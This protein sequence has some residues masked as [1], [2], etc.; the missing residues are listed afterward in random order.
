M[1]FSPANVVVSGTAATLVYSPAS[2]GV[3]TC[4]IS[5]PGPGSLFLGT[6]ST[7]TATTGLMI[8]AGATI[9]FTQY[10]YNIYG[11]GAGA[12]TGGSLSVLAGVQ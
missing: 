10:A 3:P 1:P 11:I 8:P 6:G 5:N 9:Q 12:G 4:F 2:V 7:V